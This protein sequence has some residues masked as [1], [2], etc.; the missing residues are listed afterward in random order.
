MQI[1]DPKS[2]DK[3]SV[4]KERVTN[5]FFKFGRKDIFKNESKTD[6]KLENSIVCPHLEKGINKIYYKK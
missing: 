3:Q 6:A 2:A 1:E 4:M 5:V